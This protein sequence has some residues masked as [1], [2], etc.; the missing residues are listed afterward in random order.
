MPESASFSEQALAYVL[1]AIIG[2]GLVSALIFG[3]RL[4]LQPR[5][6][7]DRSAASAS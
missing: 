5:S 6:P 1:S 7:E 4:L 2:I 3:L